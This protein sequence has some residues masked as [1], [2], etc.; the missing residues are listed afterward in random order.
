MVFLPN[1]SAPQRCIFSLLF[2]YYLY[3]LPTKLSWQNGTSGAGRKQLP[4][5]STKSNAPRGHP[6]VTRHLHP[7]TGE[8]RGSARRYLYRAAPGTTHSPGVSPARPC[9]PHPA[10]LA[11]RRTRSPSTPR[12]RRGLSAPRA[13]VPASARGGLQRRAA[14]IA[15]T[16]LPPPSP[17][18][19]WAPPS[20]PA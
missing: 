11:Q 2:H 10:G 20:C 15:A 6:C 5:S 13:A 17:L 18:T 3:M 9:P 1:L 12:P 8:Y 14:L 16:L 19:A 7:Y 4:Q